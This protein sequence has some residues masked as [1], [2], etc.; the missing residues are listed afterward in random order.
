MNLFRVRT[1]SRLHF[2]PL[3]W[4][5]QATRQFGGI[6]LMIAAPG[7]ELTARA[8][9]RWSANGPLGE[10][11]LQVAQ[12]VAARLVE[13]GITVPPVE[14]QTIRQPAEHT[15]LGVGTQVSLAVGQLVTAVAGVDVPTA[16]MLAAWTGRAVRSGIG[17]HGF[18][19]GG[20]LVDGGHSASGRI[21]PLIAH[22][23]FPPEWS[24]LIIQPR[25]APGL[26]GAA[27]S[28]AFVQL[29]PIPEPV[30][31]RLCRL[32]LLGM[33][34]AVVEHD[35]EAFGAALTELQH[36]VGQWFAPLQG[37]I[38]AH[39]ESAA[40]VRELRSLELHGAG[41]SSWGPTLY[42][43]SQESDENRK[44]LL[45]QLR[46]RFRLDTVA[47]FWTTASTTGAI[48]ETEE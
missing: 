38:Y 37:G 44:R 32:V 13:T 7:L 23:G 17:L 19:R 34:P 10:R 45:D 46:K 5:P 3:S 9:S 35:L 36:H 2:G 33:L 26:H 43:F 39:P 27:E 42:A 14:F 6:G 24:I 47:S 12:Q 1:P 31:D 25:T 16:E 8:A 4:G 41:Q 48:V 22:A 20:L 30:S 40:I 29:P 15:G 18:F 11:I 28:R 21:P